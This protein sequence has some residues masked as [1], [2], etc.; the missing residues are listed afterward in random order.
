MRNEPG[1]GR[2]QR[3]L[4]DEET[5]DRMLRAAIDMINQQGLTVSLDHIRFEDV[6]RDADVARSTAYRHWPYRDLFFSDLIKE[7]ART[8]TPGIVA[9]EVALIREIIDEHEDWL[10]S[11]Q[12]RPALILELVRRLALFDF[13]SVLASPAWRTYLALHATFSGL[14]DGDLRDQVQTA[15]NQ[16]ESSHNA[17][18]ARAWQQI[19]AVIGYRLR[20]ELA[21]GFDTLATLL[22][23]SMRGLVLAALSTPDVATREI[24][25][26]PPGAAGPEPWSLPALAMANTAMALLEPDP[27][28]DSD[29]RR[30]AAVH[31]A[32]DAWAEAP[33]AAGD[34][35]SNRPGR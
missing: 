16:A 3:R 22:S 34:K 4:S 24:I 14:A 12:Q 1:L 8:A 2:R 32:L 10:H 9:D 26:C 27:D 19:A 5:R 18:I 25:A 11:P 20:P 17:L 21:A 23:A 28:A 29:E 35:R 7:L 30:T 33:P 6:I 15:L 31:E 13:R